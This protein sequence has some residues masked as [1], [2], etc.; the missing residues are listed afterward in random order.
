[1]IQLHNSSYRLERINRI[2]KYI[3]AI[4]FLI[5]V[6]LNRNKPLKS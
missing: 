2:V 4:T 1:M 3:N 6:Q 5:K